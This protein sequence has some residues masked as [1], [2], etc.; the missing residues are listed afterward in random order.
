MERIVISAYVD[1]PEVLSS[2]VA[3]G[4]TVTKAL[5][6]RLSPYLRDHIRRF[7]QYALEMDELPPAL[8]LKPLPVFPDGP[9]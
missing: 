9:K 8:Y 5:V 7:G 3:E 4:L 1:L 2:I 6:A